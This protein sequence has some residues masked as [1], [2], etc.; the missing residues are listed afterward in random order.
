MSAGL[1]HFYL[2]PEG[3]VSGPL[4]RAASRQGLAIRLHDCIASLCSGLR[5]SAVGQERRL[6]VLVGAQAVCP[7]LAQ[8]IRGA[9]PSVGVVALVPE[10]TPA[11]LELAMY[12]GVDACWPLG[13]SPTLLAMVLQRQ[14]NVGGP[15]TANGAST[16]SR[17]DFPG[18]AGVPAVG[19]RLGMRGWVIHA[20][21][22][23]HITLT[24]AERDIVLALWHAPG[25]RLAH[26]DLL[27]V[28]APVS[29]RGGAPA[30]ARRLSVLVSRL[31]KKFHCAGVPMPVRSV[32]GSGY[33]LTV[34]FP[35][36]SPGIGTQTSRYT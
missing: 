27:N 8:A 17:H 15:A 20:P 19:W 2:E 4:Q 13:A 3:S 33:E 35:A 14:L 36:P 22:G 34:D 9:D 6:V 10:V 5:P 31:R 23:A 1:I 32:R 24:T 21:R 18:P 12:A 11:T 16:R 7:R 25:H 26:A 29:E 28:I 30:A